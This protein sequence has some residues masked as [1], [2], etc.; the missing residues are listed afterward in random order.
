MGKNLRTRR[1]GLEV[2]KQSEYY[3]I[4]TAPPPN[5]ALPSEILNLIILVDA[6]TDHLR[7]NQ[8]WRPALVPA[9][10]VK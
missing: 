9:E 10:K 1:A 8:Y 7:E 2:E 5:D 6:A 4:K 3:R